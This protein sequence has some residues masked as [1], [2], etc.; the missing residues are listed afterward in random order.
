MEV[1]NLQQQH[2][3]HFHS[4]RVSQSQA[5]QSQAA[6]LAGD[7]ASGSTVIAVPGTP[8]RVNV[9]EHASASEQAK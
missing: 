6:A 7:V 3:A 8:V 9:S 2:A 4:M 1:Q 5:Q